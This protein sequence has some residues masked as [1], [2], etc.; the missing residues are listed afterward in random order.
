MVL[1]RTSG[2]SNNGRTIQMIVA[3]MTLRERRRHERAALRQREVRR[4]CRH[5]IIVAQRLID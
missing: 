2:Q 1:E 5:P 4:F 3:P